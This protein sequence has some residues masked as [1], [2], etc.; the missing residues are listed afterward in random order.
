M[1]TENLSNV[2]FKI[3]HSIE[4]SEELLWERQQMIE[5]K[6]GNKHNVVN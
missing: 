3:E 4:W 2:I 6:Y 1:Q 5:S